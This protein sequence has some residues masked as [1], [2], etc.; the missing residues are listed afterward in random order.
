MKSCIDGLDGNNEKYSAPWSLKGKGYILLYRFSK[1]EIQS[2][3]FLSEKFKKSFLGGFGAVMIVNYEKS[4]IGHYKELLFIPGKFRYNGEKKK[5]ISKIYVSTKKS[6]FYGRKNWAIPKELANFEFKKK[7][8]NI[9]KIVVFSN[10]DEILNMKLKSG[11][12]PFPVSTHLLPFPLVQEWK[13]RVYHTQFNGS[14]VGFLAKP[15]KLSVNPSLF[16]RIIEKKP[17]LTIKV[18]PFHISFQKAI[19]KE[20]NQK[21]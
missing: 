3:I 9:E 8:E 2:D 1:K 17:L 10:G 16:P 14:G 13:K 18:D 11:L 5:T 19:I 12:V 20:V 21:Q 15:V 7:N 6:V 4:D